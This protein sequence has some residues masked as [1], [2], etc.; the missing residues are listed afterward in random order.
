MQA[1]SSAC[2]MSA[3]Q[4]LAGSS[5]SLATTRG[6]E[7]PISSAS[8]NQPASG[9]S[10]PHLD[11]ISPLTTIFFS[12]PNIPSVPSQVDIPLRVSSLQLD[13]SPLSPHTHPRL[14]AF[15]RGCY[16]SLGCH[17]QV[18]RPTCLQP[19]APSMRTHSSPSR[20][21]STTLSRDSSC[22]SRIWVQTHFLSRY[23]RLIVT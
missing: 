17:P 22:P 7:T 3:R 11:D 19:Q 13:I 20:S 16:T 18:A 12:S 2:E 1:L 21:H 4:L 8:C 15:S 9:H 10:P 5:E 14:I 6:R 23:C